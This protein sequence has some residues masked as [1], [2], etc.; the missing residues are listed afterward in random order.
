[1]IWFSLYWWGHPSFFSLIDLSLLRWSVILV[2][3]VEPPFLLLSYRFVTFSMIC[4][5]RYICGATL[6]PSLLKIC[7]FCDD[8]LFSLYLWSH[9]S[10]FSL[11]DLWLLRWSVIFVIFVEPTLPPSLLKIC[12][13]CDDL[14]FSLYLWSHPSPFSLNDLTLLRWSFILVIFVEPPFLF[15]S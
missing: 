14:L 15:L 13:F 5:F 9:P 3:F 4:Y 8:L 10:S 6:P 12:Y 2:I 11:K 1:M 7:D